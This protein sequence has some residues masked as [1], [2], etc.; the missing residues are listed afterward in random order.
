MLMLNTDFRDGVNLEDQAG[1]ENVPTVPA[2][3][4]TAAGRKRRERAKKRA[5]RSATVT[6][7]RDSRDIDRD[8][9]CEGETVLCPEQAEIKLGFNDDGDLILRQNSWPDEDQVIIV[10]RGNIDGF[11]DSL[12]D[13]TGIPSFGRR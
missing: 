11:L 4:P 10:R 3:D 7:D 9:P 2:K 5:G 8:T 13:A 6:C 1:G 12:T